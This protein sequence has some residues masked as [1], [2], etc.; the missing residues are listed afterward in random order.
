M[1]LAY[2]RVATAALLFAGA[3]MAGAQEPANLGELL[4]KGGKRLDAAEVKA[5]LTGATTKGQSFGGQLEFVSTHAPDGRLNSRAY[6]MHPEVNPNYFGKW[7]VNDK[8]QVCW[9]VTPNDPRLKPG[10]GCT[11]YYSFN[12]AYYVAPTE[13]RSAVVRLRKIER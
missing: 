11:N 9:E 5:L 13:E 12:N 6:G 8:G 7:M 1:N 2:T 4:D 3:S 10:K